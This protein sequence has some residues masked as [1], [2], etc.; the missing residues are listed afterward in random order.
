MSNTN[1][2]LYRVRLL[3]KKSTSPMEMISYYSGEDLFNLG[4]GKT[5]SSNTK[6]KVIWNELIIPDKIEQMQLYQNLPEYLKLRS[7]KKDIMS[8]AR[9]ILWQMIDERE[10]RADSQ[11]CRVFELTLPYF[12][13]KEDCIQ[14][15][16]KFSKQLCS[17]GMIVDASIHHT[18][19]ENHNFLSAFLEKHTP[20]TEKQNRFSDYSVFLACT[21]RNYEQGN[22]LNKNREWNSKEKLK[23]WRDKW[24]STCYDTLLTY[25][26]EESL[27]WKN[28]I[29]PYIFPQTS[30]S[31]NLSI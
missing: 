15:I 3:N 24:L 27:N 8:N 9:N 4:Q 31:F 23:D 29:S 30:N 1:Q 5:F 22:F 20:K 10:T 16:Q 18:F 28:K 12:F 26:N 13:S 14:N 7:S 19:L 2:Y 25:D 21:L 11:Y 6:E 17:E